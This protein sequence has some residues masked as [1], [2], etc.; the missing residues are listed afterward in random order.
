MKKI[1]KGAILAGGILLVSGGILFGGN[2]KNTVKDVTAPYGK[3]IVKNATNV[4][5]VNYVTKT[6][7]EIEIVAADDTCEASEIKYYFSTEPISSTEK[8]PDNLWKTYADGTVET[9]TLPSLTSTNKFY[10]IF[11][12]KY[13]NTSKIYT[14]SNF[15]KTITYNANGGSEAPVSQTVQNEMPAYVTNVKPKPANENEYFLGWSTDPNATEIEYY[16]GDLISASELENDIT[17][18]AVYTTSLADVP[19]LAEKVAVGDYVNY[20]V[21]Y[22]NV[23]EAGLN[24]WRVISKDIDLDGNESI[25]TVNLVSAG[26]P[27]TYYHYDSSSTSVTNLTTNF[28]TTQFSPSGDNRYRKTGFNPY[29]SLQ[30]TFTNK[31]TLMDSSTNMPKVRAMTKKDLD[32]VYGSTT[33]YNTYVTAEKFG[34]LLAIPTASTINSTNKSY[35]CYWLASANYNN[36]L[37]NV[38]YSGNVYY[39]GRYSE[40]GV[41]PVVSL[42]STVKTTGTDMSGAWNIEIE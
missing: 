38:Y 20:P 10:A 41:R 16:E 18:Y 34:N 9:V 39:Y 33:S 35:V 12:D 2:T 24:G 3:L 27:L 5:N 11:K 28:L 4:D 17:L 21:Y 15:E 7:A 6:S 14:G 22:D 25:G 40:Y 19:T 32:R 30:E 31:Y 1:V 13:G 37:W 26:V 8:V 42:K 36:S 23:N 29:V